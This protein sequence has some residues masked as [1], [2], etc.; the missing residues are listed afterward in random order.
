MRRGISGSTLKLIAI[1]AMLTDHIGAVVLERV[2]LYTEYGY[3]NR[4]P[5]CRH[6]QHADKQGK[7]HILV[8]RHR[9]LPRKERVLLYTEYGYGNRGL[10]IL[11]YVMRLVIGRIAF[12][13]FLSPRFP[14]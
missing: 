13:I 7:K 2:L 12:P 5:V 9:Q 4:G 14:L 1:T 11:Y 8:I 3:G 6:N 10:I